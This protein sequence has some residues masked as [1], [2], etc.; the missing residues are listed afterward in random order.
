MPYTDS[1]LNHQFKF[2]SPIRI[3][4]QTSQGTKGED[5]NSH[6]SNRYKILKFR[7]QG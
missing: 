2:E 3:T 4:D 1:Y 7:Q 5:P 6:A